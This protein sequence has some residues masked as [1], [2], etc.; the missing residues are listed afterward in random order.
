MLFLF[1]LSFLTLRLIYYLG[2]SVLFRF[3]IAV[4]RIMSLFPIVKVFKIILWLFSFSFFKL[5]FFSFLKR[6]TS[7]SVHYIGIPFFFVER[8]AYLSA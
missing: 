4:P 7:L 5:T 3:R 2:Y 8:V 1:G 6:V